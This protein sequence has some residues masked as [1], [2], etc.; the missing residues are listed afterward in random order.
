MA[1]V[2]KWYKFE[3]AHQLPDHNGPCARLHGH[4]YQIGLE[5]S[6]DIF[7]EFGHTS[8]GMVIDFNEMDVVMDPLIAK[9][10]HQFL[11][12]IVDCRTT[13]ENLGCWIMD[14]LPYNR[15]NITVYVKE[16]ANSL[17]TITRGDTDKWLKDYRS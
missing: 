14:K 6:G 9:L 11:N 13:A 8:N 7:W 2:T 10:D 17:A 3:A 16:T 12:D 5:I 4:S 1:S 15:A